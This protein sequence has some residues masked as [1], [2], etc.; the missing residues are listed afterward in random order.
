VS[1]VVLYIGVCQKLINVYDVLLPFVSITFFIAAIMISC[2]MVSILKTKAKQ[3]RVL[4]TCCLVFLL[5]IMIDILNANFL[6]WSQFYLSKAIFLILFLIGIIIAIIEIPKYFALSLKSTELEKEL[7]TQ[8]LS[9]ML[10]QIQPHFMFNSLTTIM[11]L[12][13]ENSTLAR[14]TL[15]KFSLLLR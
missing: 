14:E 3:E 5:S 9:L 15:E 8:K 4:L 6:W 13:E 12:C 1:A 7:K 10:S 2:C 11:Y